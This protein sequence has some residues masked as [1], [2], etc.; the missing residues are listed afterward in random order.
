M[1]DLSPDDSQYRAPALD[2]GLDILELL[3]TTDSGLTQG[4]IARALSRTPTELYRMIDTL[5]R[6]RYLSRD[7]D[8]YALTLKLFALAHQHPP[9]RRLVAQA[10][11]ALR[12]L[13]R[14]AEQ[15]CHLATYDRGQVLVVAQFDSP[16]YYGLSIR[17]GSR[18]GLLNTGSGHVLL[19]YATPD[20]RVLMLSEHGTAPDETVPKRFDK[21]LA[22]IRKRGYERMKSLQIQGVTNLSVPVIGSGGTAVA[23]VTVPFLSRRDRS[24]APPLEAV[25]GRCK[26]AAAALSRYIGGDATEGATQQPASAESLARRRGRRAA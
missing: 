4:E 12:E 21:R 25:L 20:E 10:T 17:L 26:E 24:G 2:K 13:S 6:R 3:S 8:T 19:A 15:S 23:A 18:I 22:Q 7:G 1:N 5:V 16:K 11:P 9:L 14:W